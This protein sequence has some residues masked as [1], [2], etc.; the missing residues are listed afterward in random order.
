[1]LS[2]ERSPVL[3]AGHTHV[4]LIRRHD[5][6]LIVNPGSVGLPF[7]GRPWNGAVRMSPWAEYAILTAEDGQVSPDLRHA[8]YDVSALRDVARKSG[9]PHPEWW[10]DQW[11]RPG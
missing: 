11:V 7:D 9:M 2:G 8:P 5:S 10:Y 3:T 4:Q 1:M 6:T